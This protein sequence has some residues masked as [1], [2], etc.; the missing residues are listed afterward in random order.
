MIEEAK[1]KMIE[2]DKQLK[3]D[4]EKLRQDMD[5][6]YNEKKQGKTFRDKLNRYNKPTINV[7]IGTLSALI[8]GLVAPLFGV[9]IMKNMSG[10]MF[11]QFEQRNVLEAIKFWI[12]FMFSLAVLIWITKALSVVMFSK[13]GHNITKGVRQ[14]LY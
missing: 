11:A 2:A 6:I 13:V 12:L 14:E 10:I 9:G 1:S 8:A 5:D 4:D 3:E 7:V